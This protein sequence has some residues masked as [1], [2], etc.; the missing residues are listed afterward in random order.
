MEKTL[1]YIAGVV[2]GEGCLMVGKYKRSGN[3]GLAYRGYF[4]IANTYVP[5]LTHI[6]SIMG[7]KIIE[8]GK[9]NGCYT[10]T[11]T[12][13]EIRKWLPQLI[14]F[15]IVKKKQAEVL[16][17]FLEK[18]SSNASAPVSD[19]LN[20]FYETCYTKLKKLKKERFFYKEKLVSMGIRNCAQC[21]NQFELFSSFPKKI[22]CSKE[23]KNKIHWVR[24]NARI[25]AGIPAW[26]KVN[27]N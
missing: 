20:E 6:K 4:M 24:S 10:L 11:F 21:G 26:N 25:R 14:G 12:T 13:S 8:Q 22:Y 17:D 27:S 19:N 16:L 5:L 15:L 9:N 2:D 18:Q 23:C 7:G 1:S 3:K